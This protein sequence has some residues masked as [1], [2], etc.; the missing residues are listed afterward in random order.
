MRPCRAA[1]GILKEISLS[2]REFLKLSVQTAAAAALWSSGCLNRR[3]PSS[4]SSTGIA[5]VNDIHSQLNPTRVRRITPAD[6]LQSVQ[7]ALRR[8]A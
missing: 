6:S 7:H 3:I 5:L 2:R 4:H 8:A 1:P